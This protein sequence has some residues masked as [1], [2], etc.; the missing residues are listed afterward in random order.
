MRE[1]DADARFFQRPL[2]GDCFAVDRVGVGRVISFEPRPE[3]E[4]RESCR[5]SFS[6]GDRLGSE[7]P[8][9]WPS[10]HQ[11]ASQSLAGPVSR[12]RPPRSDRPARRLSESVQLVTLSEMSMPLGTMTSAPSNVRITLARMPIRLMV[13]D[14]SDTS[15]VSPT[16]IGRSNRRI[17]PDTK[18]LTT[19]CKPNP[20]HA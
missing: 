10:P 6:K 14:V 18:S 20:I 3:L 5:Q 11:P 8:W 9:D 17:K 15:I 13:P 19:F 7:S 16:S 12:I 4:I 1:G 2:D